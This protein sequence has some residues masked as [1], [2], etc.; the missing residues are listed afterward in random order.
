MA[1]ST[2]VNLSDHF[3]NF[4]AEQVESG[5][6]GSASEVVREGLRMVEQRE[7]RLQAV[8]QALIEGEESGQAGPL[9]MEEIKR[10]ARAMAA[11]AA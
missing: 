10:T 3:C 8:R 6:F 1:K 7:T 2:S 5:R 9:D 11:R 4:I